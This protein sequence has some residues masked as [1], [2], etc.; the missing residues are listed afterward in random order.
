MKHPLGVVPV[1][2][3]QLPAVERVLPY[4]QQ[5]QSA[6]RYSNFGPLEQ[7]LRLR[8]AEFLAVGVEQVASASNATLALAGALTVS[9]CRD[10]IVPSFTFAATAAAVTSAGHRGRFCDV[11]DDWWLRPETTEAAGL[12]PVAPFGSPPDLSAWPAEAA[13]VIDVAAPL[14]EQPDLSGLPASWAA[15]FSLHAT[16]ALGSGEGGLVVFGDASKADEFRRWT[17][18]GF[19]EHRSSLA[20]GV[21]AKMSEIQAAYSLASFDTWGDERQGWLAARSEARSVEAQF[22]SE[23]FRRRSNASAVNPYWIIE[24]NST[25]AAQIAHDA[26]VE[27]RIETRKWWGEGCHRMPAFQG[28]ERGPLVTTER[29]AA[30]YIGLPF[31]RGIGDEELSRIRSALAAVESRL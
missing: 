31:Y 17:N 26:F 18:F 25:H 3:A 8:A 27:H 14:G 20:Q 24:F 11:G 7:Q 22:D 29:A 1:M 21:N 13:I 10:W 9:G 6:G 23:L 4:L 5:M 15:V 30:N 2:K 28:W 19:D 16:K 12:V